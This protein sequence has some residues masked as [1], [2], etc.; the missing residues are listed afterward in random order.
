MVIL[1]LIILLIAI[2][3]KVVYNDKF[4]LLT[5]NIQLSNGAG[6]ATIE[7]PSGFTRE[8][9]VSISVGLDI[10]GTDNFSYFFN[11][12]SNSCFEVRLGPENL[13]LNAKSITGS[14]S[15]NLK[16]YRIVLMKIN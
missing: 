7:Y 5:G 16:Q 2:G 8:N 1:L 14:G 11:G 9:C 13:F 12:T 6:N 3:G 4:A 15:S 10:I